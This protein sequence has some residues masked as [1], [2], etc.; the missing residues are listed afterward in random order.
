MGQVPGFSEGIS[1]SFSTGT[2]GSTQV[3]DGDF[4]LSAGFQERHPVTSPP[5]NQKK[6]IYPPALTPNF[7]YKNF[8]PRKWEDGW[9][10]LGDWDCHI[11]TIDWLLLLFSH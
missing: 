4:W 10:E 7:S 1:L 8:S 6:V 5:N 9:D 2:E 11:Y 3:K